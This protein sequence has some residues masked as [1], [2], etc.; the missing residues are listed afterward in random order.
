MKVIAVD[1]D[2][3]LAAPSSD[4]RVIA[5]P[6]PVC[7]FL[8]RALRQHGYTVCIWTCRA[9]YVA[10]AWLQEHGL[11][12]YVDYVNDSPLPADDR[13]L[14]FHAYIGDDAVHFTHNSNDLYAL[15]K[16]LESRQ[17]P[18]YGMPDTEFTSHK[19]GLMLR[20]VGQRYLDEF[21]H[22]W[23]T[24][25][26]QRAAKP[27]CLLTICSHA[28]PY[29]KSYIHMS[30]RKSLHHTGLL[31]DI[32]YAHISNAGI[33]PSDAGDSYPYD[34]YDWNNALASPYVVELLRKKM[35]ADLTYWDENFAHNY[36]AVV[37][38]L[39]AP[40][41][42]S[43]IAREAL[44]DKAQYCFVPPEALPWALQH[45]ADD[46]LTLPRNLADLARLIAKAY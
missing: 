26:P 27:V 3:T 7:E 9:T 36:S 11:R 2:G 1:I 24:L 40:G 29:F 23:K 42:T 8:L 16:D 32:E 45:D 14:P 37:V 5:K 17:Y 13:K 44:G 31:D 25:W 4:P 34:S 12:H 15:I 18:D 39:R 19:P 30:I 46:C 28:K 21:A 38:Y 22:H 41:N 33:I 43:E 10:E 20:G 6:S 35:R